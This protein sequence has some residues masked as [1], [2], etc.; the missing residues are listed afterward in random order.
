MVIQCNNCKREY[1]TAMVTSGIRMALH[2][3]VA[4]G[5]LCG[6]LWRMLS[7]WMIPLGVVLWIFFAWVSWESPRWLMY[8]RYGRKPCPECG[9]KAWNRPGYS[10]WGL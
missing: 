2:A 4:T 6:I 5:V 1:G 7:Y 3:S 10:G 9:V 8:L